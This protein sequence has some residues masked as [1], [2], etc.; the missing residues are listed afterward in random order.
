MISV[1]HETEFSH[2]SQLVVEDPGLVLTLAFV[3][4]RM[5]GRHGQVFPGWQMIKV[6]FPFHLILVFIKA[7]ASSR[8]FVGASVK[9]K[10]RPPESIFSKRTFRPCVI[11]SSLSPPLVYLQFLP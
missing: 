4:W 7:S 5:N 2:L 9:T 1:V 11:L 3:L 10:T 8:F 6:W